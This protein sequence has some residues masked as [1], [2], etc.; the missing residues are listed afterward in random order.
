MGTKLVNTLGVLTGT[1][2]VYAFR[3]V[4]ENPICVYFGSVDRNPAS[5]LLE[6]CLCVLRESKYGT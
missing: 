4:E 5:V 3:S 1:L 2:S 6:P